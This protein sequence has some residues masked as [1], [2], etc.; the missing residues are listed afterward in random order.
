V[1]FSYI[2]LDN[3]LFDFA[4]R[5]GRLYLIHWQVLSGESSIKAGAK[6]FGR[7]LKT[8]QELKKERHFS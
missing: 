1:I 4:K 8:V 6:E 3:T 2:S 5:K 7:S